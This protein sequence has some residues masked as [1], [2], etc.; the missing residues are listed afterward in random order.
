MAHGF[1]PWSAGAH[2]P[3]AAVFV[4]ACEGVEPIARHGPFFCDQHVLSH[5]LSQK[6]LNYNYA[7]SI[8]PDLTA[9]SD[10]EQ[11]F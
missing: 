8:A 11:L 9:Y 5:D 6:I 2:G 7:K 4:G 10:Q 1:R 3:D